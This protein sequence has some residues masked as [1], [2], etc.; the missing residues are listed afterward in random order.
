MNCGQ[1]NARATVALPIRRLFIG[2]PSSRVASTSMPS[3]KQGKYSGSL[4]LNSFP[5][6]ATSGTLYFSQCLLSRS[7]LHFIIIT[8]ITIIIVIIKN[9]TSWLSFEPSLCC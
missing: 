8:I 5:E 7:Q 9:L 3:T 1:L 2:D 6:T 4:V